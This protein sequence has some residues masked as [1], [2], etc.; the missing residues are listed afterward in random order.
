[1]FFW[2]LSVLGVSLRLSWPMSLGVTAGGVFGSCLAV[3]SSR[4]C[5]S[6]S[7]GDIFGVLLG[8]ALGDV[9]AFAFAGASLRMSLRLSCLWGSLPSVSLRLSLEQVL[10]K[11]VWGASAGVCLGMPLRLFRGCL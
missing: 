5:L 6:E 7:W 4:G 9:F 8:D 2:G 3:T 1:M 11:C 10:G